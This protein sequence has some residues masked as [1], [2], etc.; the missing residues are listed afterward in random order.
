MRLRHVFVIA[1][2]CASCLVVPVASAAPGAAPAAA[3]AATGDVDADVAARRPTAKGQMRELIYDDEAIDGESLR[4][5]HER[6]SFRP[7]GKHPSLI[8]VRAHF[9]PQL[10]QMAADI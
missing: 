9:I 2:V 10:L 8:Q 7:P 3:P 4:P 5:D 1:G 6:V